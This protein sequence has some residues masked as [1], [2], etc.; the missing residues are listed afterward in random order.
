M[1]MLLKEVKKYQPLQKVIIHSVD[2]A[3]YQVSVMIN[4]VEYYVKKNQNDFLRAHN[5]LQIQREFANVAYLEMVIRHSS[6]YDE[7]VGQPNKSGNNTLEVPFG[8]NKLYWTIIK[9]R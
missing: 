4:N 8:D 9:R 7:M 6:P 1:P 3:L 2:Q 5:P